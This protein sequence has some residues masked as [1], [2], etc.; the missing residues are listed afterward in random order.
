M[1]RDQEPKAGSAFNRETPAHYLV[2]WA[3]MADTGLSAAAKCLAVVLLLQYRNHKTGQCNPSFGELAKRVGRTRRPVIDALIELRDRGWIDWQGTKGGSPKN[4][5][6]FQFF[7]TPRPVVQTALVMNT[8]PVSS[9]ASTSAADS[10]QPVLQT[11]HEPSIEPSR[12]I[13]GS[14]RLRGQEGVKVHSDSVHADRWRRWWKSNGTREPP[15]SQRDGYY[16][17]PL[18]SLDPPPIAESAA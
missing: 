9:S 15:Y 14:L 16:L 6:N 1:T 12:T 8:T 10:Q 17:K 11:A 13:S 4:T 18:P 5:N 3:I 7:L 2:L